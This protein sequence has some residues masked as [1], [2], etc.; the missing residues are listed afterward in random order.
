MAKLVSVKLA[1]GTS[2]DLRM[3][4]VGTLL[5]RDMWIQPIIPMSLCADELGCK[6]VWQGRS[7]KVLRPT[8]GKLDIE[9]NRGCP[10]I[11]RDVCLGLIAELENERGEAMLRTVARVSDEAG[12]KDPRWS[13]VGDRRPTPDSIHAISGM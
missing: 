2:N 12:A 7:C 13:N 11:D 8:L 4:A 9:M 5:S 10:E 3:S 1:S 6:I